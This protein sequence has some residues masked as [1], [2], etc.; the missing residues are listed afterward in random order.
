QNSSAP[1]AGGKNVFLKLNVDK[2]NVYQGEG[3]VLTYKLYTK[4]NLVNYSISKLPALNGFWSQ[5]IA[6]AQQLQFHSENY[7][8]IS[9][10]VAEIKKMVIFPQRSGNLELD[11]MEGEVIARVQVKRQQQRSNDP[12]DQ[13]FNDP[14]FN[15]NSWQDVKVA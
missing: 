6:L 4:V 11:P 7:D 10:K 9:Y 3:I 14:F 12:F 15:F 13:F 2:T 5:D 1:I 8:G